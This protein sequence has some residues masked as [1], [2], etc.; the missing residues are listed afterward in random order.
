MPRMFRLVACAALWASSLAAQGDSLYGAWCARCH[1][2]DAHG[3][4]VASVRTDV[5]DRG[6]VSLTAF[7]LW[8]FGDAPLLKGW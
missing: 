3:T 4:P 2:A 5:P 7:L 6:Q 8:D 1:G